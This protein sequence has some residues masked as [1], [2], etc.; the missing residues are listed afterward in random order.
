MA[1][2]SPSRPL[3]IMQN[4]PNTIYNIKPISQ[5][6]PRPP[7]SLPLP[8]RFLTVEPHCSASKFIFSEYAISQSQRD[9]AT[10]AALVVP[11][12]AVKLIIT[13]G[14]AFAAVLVGKGDR[15]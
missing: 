15:L 9:R 11:H 8:P 2:W 10:V 12:I 4:R 3:R 14:E 13:R 6:L 1:A 7:P 5:P